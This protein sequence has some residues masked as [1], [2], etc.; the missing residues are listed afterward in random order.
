M[1]M[2]TVLPEPTSIENAYLF[3]KMGLFRLIDHVGARTESQDAA[4]AI[5]AALIAGDDRDVRPVKTGGYVERLKKQSIT[6]PVFIKNLAQALS[7]R[8]VGI[9]VNQVR[10][11]PDIDVGKSMELIGQR[12]F[13][14]Q[15]R[16]CGYLNYD[17]AAWKSLRNRRLLMVDF[18]H[19]ILARR[20]QDIA[21]SVLSSLG[22]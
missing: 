16:S 5:K 6:H 15:T 20:M 21:K 14:Y 12:Y 11:Q 17:E 7:G 13:G 10:G 8:V 4:E 3:L 19:S 18:P 9:T 1:A 22:Y 2:V